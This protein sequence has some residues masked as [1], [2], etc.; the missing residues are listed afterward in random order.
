MEDKS[1]L[2]KGVG[3][4]KEGMGKISE[5]VGNIVETK[6]TPRTAAEEANADK[7]RVNTPYKPDVPP[8]RNPFG[9]TQ[10]EIEA[11]NKANALSGKTPQ[12]T[13]PKTPFVLDKT[14][15]KPATPDYFK[16]DSTNP[17]QSK[18][19]AFPGATPDTVQPDPKVGS[20]FT[21]AQD[22]AN[23]GRPAAPEAK[24]LSKTPPPLTNP[25]R[26]APFEPIGVVETPKEPGPGEAFTG[27]THMAGMQK[28]A[29]VPLTAAPVAVAKPV[30]K[31]IPDPK[32]V[33]HAPNVKKGDGVTYIGHLKK[34][35]AEFVA[36]GQ[37]Y[38]VGFFETE[39][40]A[41]EGIAKA[42][43]RMIP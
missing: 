2:Q 11:A 1:K 41:V 23:K 35:L 6:V 17:G 33:P 19:A 42:K 24:G 9:P 18:A 37:T 40:L 16:A 20:A 32:P 27:A 39:K 7:A 4:I 8:Q 29:P 12:N 43:A 21:G 31:V 14:T 3:Q 26:P 28:L 10:A 36:S 13:L 30:E 15:G 38:H 34:F 5:G 25:T 22:M